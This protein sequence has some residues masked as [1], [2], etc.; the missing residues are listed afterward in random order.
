MGLLSWK[1]Y[2][3]EVQKSSK[4][5][6]SQETLIPGFTQFLT[7]IANFLFCEGRLVPTFVSTQLRFSRNF[8][9]PQ[10]S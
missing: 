5:E 1:N 9:T 8:L 4:I 2:F 6:K 10:N 3:K 7:A